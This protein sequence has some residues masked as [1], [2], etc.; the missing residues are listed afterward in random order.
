MPGRLKMRT[1]GEQ[2]ENS[3]RRYL[4]YEQVQQCQRRRVC[5]VQVF[6]DQEDR[7]SFGKFQEDRDNSFECLLALTLG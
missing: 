3:S 4:L 7:L 6:D 5:P 1:T 2:C